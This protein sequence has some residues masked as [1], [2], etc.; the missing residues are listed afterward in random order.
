[1][2]DLAIAMLCCV[3]LFAV[4]AVP[5]GAPA[6]DI[7]CSQLANSPFQGM[8]VEQC[9]AME[10]YARGAQA[11]MDNPAG[12]RPG[13]EKMSCADIEAEMRT[14]SGGTVPDEH[15]AQGKDAKQD[16][17]TEVTQ[18]EAIAATMM[19]GGTAG[20]IAASAAGPVAS[21]AM[22]E[23]LAAEQRIVGDQMARQMA[24]K[25]RAVVDAANAG[26]ADMVQA[27][28]ANPRFTRLIRLA[29]DKGC[30]GEGGNQ[31]NVEPGPAAPRKQ[32][33]GAAWRRESK[34]PDCKLR[35]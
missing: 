34:A 7:D 3:G 35:P 26:I 33:P 9:K 17:D 25:Q 30:R 20:Q 27:M 22:Q 15:V 13:D 19:V 32:E 29:M 2:R 14:M 11:A 21:A 8:T 5:A 31:G 24:P 1:M 18:D 28:Q 4:T 10:G 23:K 16:F 6:P 12:M